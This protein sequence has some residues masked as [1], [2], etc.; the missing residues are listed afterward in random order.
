MWR[1]CEPRRTANNQVSLEL[2]GSHHFWI[3]A[4][5]HTS[6]EMYINICVTRLK[7]LV[8]LAEHQ[9]HFLLSLC[10]LNFIFCIVAILGNLLVIRALLKASM[11]ATLK[12]MFL[13]LAFSDLSVGLLVQPMH[14]TIIAVILY[15]TSERND[16]LDF[17]CPVF[18]TVYLMAAYFFAVASFC[19]IV[20]IAV[21]RLLAVSLHLRYRE[22]VTMKR[23]LIVLFM[24]WSTSGL[25]AL[26][27]ILLPNYNDIVAVV[28]EVLGLL[29]TSVAYFQI[30]KVAR[31]HQN[32][33]QAQCQ[34]TT[35]LEKMR[36]GRVERS[37]YNA[38]YVYAVFVICYLP[39]I[40]CGILL[41]TSE[42][43]MSLIT[44]FYVTILLI[45]LNSSVNL[46]VYCWRYREIRETVKKIFT[47]ACRRNRNGTIDL[48]NLTIQEPRT[49]WFQRSEV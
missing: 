42:F 6:R 40:F 4:L 17:L 8:R 41:V 2:R 24:L 29:V 13:S 25:M 18:V 5:S 9:N 15:K 48:T 19:S 21:D 22:F 20:T 16:D 28:L 7:E 30:F 39:N 10:V 3:S 23:V 32:Q 49:S 38:F 37:A 35:D 46:V 33:I 45:Y 47:E 44:A 1:I 14:G 36:V 31:Y 27:Y 34:I 26:V 11:P 43:S 12:A